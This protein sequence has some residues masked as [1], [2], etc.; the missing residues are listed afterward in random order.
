[1]HSS[2]LPSL[3]SSQHTQH[4]VRRR[5]SGIR[6]R[7]RPSCSGNRLCLTPRARA[8][9]S[10]R[11]CVRSSSGRPHAT[12]RVRVRLRFSTGPPE[13][14]HSPLLPL[15]ATGS[16]SFRREASRS[17]PPRAPPSP[18][19]LPAPSL[20]SF[21]PFEL[22]I[23]PPGQARSLR[24]FLP[25]AALARSLNFSPPRR[26][27]LKCYSADSRTD[28]CPGYNSYSTQCAAYIVLVYTI[29]RMV[30]RGS[31]LRSELIEP[32]VAVPRL[33]L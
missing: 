13:F 6:P 1:M 24:C 5:P 11:P 19:R 16:R 17:H 8:R 21:G 15:R 4:A 3:I 28:A 14:R 27:V 10:P 22:G 2:E 25:F 23:S 20:P 9:V 31:P 30:L 32:C 12:Q 18:L 33:V 26:L 7:G 29:V